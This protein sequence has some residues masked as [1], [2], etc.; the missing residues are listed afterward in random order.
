MLITPIV[1]AILLTPFLTH[2]RLGKAVECFSSLEPKDFKTIQLFIDLSRVKESLLT[3]IGIS[4]LLVIARM[5]AP[6]Q[7]KQPEHV[8]AFTVFSGVACLAAGV[9]LM[10]HYVGVISF[11]LRLRD[12]LAPRDTHA[13]VFFQVV[14]SALIVPL[15][16]LLVPS[17][18]NLFMVVLNID[19]SVTTI[20]NQLIGF[21]VANLAIWY[22]VLIRLSSMVKPRVQAKLKKQK[23]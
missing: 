2:K 13:S 15:G 7:F 9:I 8:V 11:F 21:S 5:V 1:L 16:A 20:A 19:V 3:T 6:D 22:L 4:I 17:L 18:A 14:G 10:E 12:V 23:R